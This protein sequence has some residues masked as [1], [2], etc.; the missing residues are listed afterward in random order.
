[1]NHQRYLDQPVV[2]EQPRIQNWTG[3][4]KLSDPEVE[5]V[6]VDIFEVPTE[7]RILG[8]TAFLVSIDLSV[9][10]TNDEGGRSIVG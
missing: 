10:G 6:S 3:K 9:A 1:M 4:T 7:G 5:L 2:P 8:L